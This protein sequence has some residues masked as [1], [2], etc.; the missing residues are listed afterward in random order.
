MHAAILRFV[1]VKCA[2][3]NAVTPTKVRCL[4]A[5][6]LLFQHRYDLLVRE[7]LLHFIRPLFGRTLHRFGGALGA[8]VNTAVTLGFQSG[9]TMSDA[10]DYFATTQET[11]E[12]VYKQHSPLHNKA[13]M[14]PMQRLGT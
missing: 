10:T 9:L 8:Q 2:L 1:F 3:A 14:G 7:S 12:R 5:S 13:A 6:F 4:L 11:L